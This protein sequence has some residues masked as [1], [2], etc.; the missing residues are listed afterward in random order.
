[1]ER[2]LRAKELALEAAV[3]VFLGVALLGIAAGAEHPVAVWR[4]LLAGVLVAFAGR[5][6]AHVALA[7]LAACAPEAEEE[8]KPV[9]ESP[10][11]SNEREPRAGT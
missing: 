3:L 9:A 10:A 2:K 1:M 7:A 11:P 8:R 5:V 4:G 6:P